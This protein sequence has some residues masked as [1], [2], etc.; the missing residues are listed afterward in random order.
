MGINIEEINDNNFKQLVLEAENI[1]LVDFN[2]Q[3]C[4]PCRK[5]API[6]EQIQNEFAQDI[7]IVKMDVDKNVATPKEYGVATL[8]ALL[9][10][11][12]S[13][14]KEFMVGMLSKSAIV[15]NIKKYL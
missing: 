3:W 9:I 12:E 2:A 14:V 1:V 8:P 4:G 7:K 15:S 5:L 13:E 11:K 6:L 10:F